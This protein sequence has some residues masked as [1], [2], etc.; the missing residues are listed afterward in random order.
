MGNPVLVELT[1]GLRRESMHTGAVA[2]ARANGELVAAVGDV[3]RAVFPRS[4][5]KPLQALPLLETGAADRY[6]FGA[7]E[8]A[9]ACGSHAGTR[10]QAATVAKML[11]KAGLDVSALGCG[12]QEPLD[13]SAARE[14]VL[15]G[16]APTALNHN[17]SGK[18]AGMLATAAHKAEAIEGYWLPGHPVQI[19]ILNALEGVT[20]QR[21]ASDLRGIDG[22]SVPNWAVPL[23]SLAGAFAR[24][25]TGEGLGRERR[26]AC[27]QLAR[28]CWAEPMLVAGPGRLDSVLMRA[29]P[30]K[31]LIKSGAEGVHCGGFPALGLGFALKIDDGA[32]RGADFVAAS[33]V[34][35]LYPQ[36]A[37]LGPQTP[38][39]NFRGLT[40]GEIRASPALEGVLASLS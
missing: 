7:A 36:V 10:E 19:R 4:A 35:R 27:R 26:R 31:V 17:C 3:E 30:G 29:L 34:R 39:H 14:L 33:L 1:R 9:L 16:L 20:G 15:A 5:I 22:C 13:V 11:L 6:G 12:I 18:H 2:V 37:A 32:K 40:V 24:F 23:R 28:A 38:L 25:V 21:L 8:L